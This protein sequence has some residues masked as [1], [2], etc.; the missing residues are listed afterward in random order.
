SS[1]RSSSRHCGRPSPSDAHP[2]PAIVALIESRRPLRAFMLSLFSLFRTFSVRYLGQ[3]WDRAA[4]IV[5]SIGLGVAMLVSTQLLNQC[6]DA[7]ATESMTPGSDTADLMVTS[8]R[9]VRH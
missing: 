6:L 4:L 9:R 3:R 2:G 8:N 1:R 7:A 5:A